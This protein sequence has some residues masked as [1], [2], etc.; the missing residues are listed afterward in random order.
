MDTFSATHPF[1]HDS[2]RR[3]RPAPTTSTAIAAERYPSSPSSRTTTSSVPRVGRNNRSYRLHRRVPA[4]SRNRRISRGP[5]VALILQQPASG[6][7]VHVSVHDM[8]RVSSFISELHHF[9]MRSIHKQK[10][11]PSRSAKVGDTEQFGSF[12]G[13][14]HFPPS[15]ARMRAPSNGLIVKATRLSARYVEMDSRIF[16]VDVVQHVPLLVKRA[17]K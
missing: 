14:L 6:R 5:R 8:L 16:D 10:R 4:P 15:R 13:V 9:I 3:G 1:A 2:H 7:C 17:Q 12:Y 11:P